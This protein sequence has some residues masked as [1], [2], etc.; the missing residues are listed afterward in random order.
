MGAAG[1]QTVHTT[2][3]LAKLRELMSKND[4][5]AFVVPSE[6]QHSS[7]YLAHCDERR[8]FISGFNGSAGCAVITTKGAFL[9]TD[10]RYFLQAEQQ[11][12]QYVYC[13]RSLVVTNSLQELDVDETRP[14]RRTDMARLSV[15]ENSLRIGIDPTL[16]SAVDAENLTKSLSPLG[17]SLVSLPHNIVD[18]VW[19]KDRPSR[20]NATVSH[21]DTKY[22]GEGHVEKI[23]RLRE[24]LRKKKAKGLV[25]TMLDEVAWLFNL[26]G[27]DIDF[28]PV[29]FAYAVVTMDKAVLFTEASRLDAGARTELGNDVEIHAYDE[30]FA[31]L[32]AL[33]EQLQLNKDSP[34]LLGDKASLAVAEA[35]GGKSNYTIDRSPIADLKAI[36]NGTELEG[37]RQCH[38]RDGAALARYFAWLEAELVGGRED[39]TESQ[40]ADQLE[41]YRSELA[42]FKGLSF[43]TIS[44][45][46]PNGAIIHYSPDPQ[47]CAIVKKEQIYLCDSGAQF[48]DGTTDVTRTWHFG[49][50]TAE[51]RRA[52]TRVLQGHIAIDAA[53]FPVGTTGYVIDSWARRALWRDGLDYRH[54][55]GHGVGHFLNVHEGPHGIG[56]RIAYNNSPLK[57]G[58]TVSNEPGYYADG[59]FGIRIENIVLVRKADTP[60]NFGEKGYLGFEHVTM[61]PIHTK[62][63][64]A[65]LL[66]TE[67]RAWLNAYHAEVLE[68]VT[69]LLKNDE[70]ALRWLTKECQAI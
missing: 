28:N 2:E 24:E 57:P 35:M 36:K 68:K 47:D 70:R 12:D 60:H 30:F 50:P 69:P 19:H 6:D 65:D 15:K 33:P 27:A 25:V 61:A 55:T 44:S 17:S 23:A 63:V 40:A 29:F 31:Y 7:E 53:V 4:V 22:S 21:L 9:F 46:G 45:T 14:A 18:L 10:G 43:P 5:G 66:S 41:K 20:P 54:G 48:L 13:T 42:M 56:V 3:R 52:F 38:I 39:L 59:K 34:F 16:I 67:E 51:E 64:D 26:R 58:M 62:L 11:L 49:T 1:A 37:F 8:A 32:K